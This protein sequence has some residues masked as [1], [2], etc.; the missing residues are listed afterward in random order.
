MV[1]THPCCRT[2]LLAPHVAT[3]YGVPLHET[4]LL[5]CVAPK[6]CPVIVIVAARAAGLGEML[7]TSG[8]AVKLTPSL[9][10]LP[11]T[12]TTGP[13][14][15]FA[16]TEVVIDV[17]LHPMMVALAPLNVTLP[18][19]WVAPKPVPVIV[20]GVP[21]F[22]EFGETELTLSAEEIVKLTPLL[23]APPTVATIL[24]VVAPLGTGT[25]MLISLQLVGT[26]VVPLNL[27]VLTP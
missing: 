20:I 22:P 2:M 23:A 16:G 3:G 15:A 1:C 21:V 4:T 18:P 13:E 6:F 26:A 8:C 19:F 24:P 27:T 5:P 25:V 9:D 14:I 12:T 10:A 11:T 7:S 17:L